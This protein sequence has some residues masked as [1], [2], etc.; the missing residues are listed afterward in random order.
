[1]PMHFDD[2]TR[3][4]GEV[5]PFPRVLDNIETTA[6]WFENFRDTWDVGVKLYLP[7]FGRPVAVSEPPPSTT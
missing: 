5:V 2:F 1:M 7:E 3:P 4:F 6:G